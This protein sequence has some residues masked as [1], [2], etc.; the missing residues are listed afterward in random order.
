MQIKTFTITPPNAERSE[1]EVNLFLRSHRILR[2]E[3]H[4]VEHDSSWAILVEYQDEQ[5]D[6]LSPVPKRRVK[7]DATEGM[8]VPCVEPQQQLARQP[9]QQ[10]RPALGPIA[11]PSIIVLM[12]RETGYMSRPACLISRRMFLFA[13]GFSSALEAN[14]PQ[15][16]YKRINGLVNIFFCFFCFCLQKCVTLQTDGM[17]LLSNSF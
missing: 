17:G 10:P 5:P 1:D 6:A 3:H 4:F 9:Q 16:L 8:S 11:C 15:V 12:T 13:C 14:E 7:K 2:V